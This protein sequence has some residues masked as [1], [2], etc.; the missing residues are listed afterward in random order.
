MNSREIALISVFAAIWIGSQNALGPIVGRISI[1]PFSIHGVVN[2]VIGWLLMFIL[3]EVSGKFGRVSIMATIAALGTRI[4]RLSPLRGLV[5]GAGYALGGVV[6]DLLFFAPYMRSLEGKNRRTYLLIIAV[7]SGALALTPYLLFQL[8]ILGIQGFIALMP[9]YAYY[10]AK[11][12]IF[13]ILGTSIG[14]SILP[15]IK[16]LAPKI[17]S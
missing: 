14:L 7:I 17:E 10:M 12:I 6:F 9:L 1:G 5:V 16:M 3:A 11:G 4:I 2:R 13:S 15:R 8:S